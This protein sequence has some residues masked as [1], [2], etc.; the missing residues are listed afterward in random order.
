M[1]Q[2]KKVIIHFNNISSEVLEAVQKKY[3]DGYQD[4]IFKVTKPNG[5]FFH[6]ITID[7]K[8][9][10][11]LIKVDVKIDNATDEKIAEQLFSKDD[12]PDIDIK[13]SGEDEEDTE[14]HEK[15]RPDDD[16]NF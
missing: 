3:P 4:H 11:Y 10:S 5:D 13:S 15:P 14:S 16:D 7:T 12:I 6:A 9:A 1:E 8:D 2:K